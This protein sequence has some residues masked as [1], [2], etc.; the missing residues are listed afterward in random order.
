MWTVKPIWPKSTWTPWGER[1]DGP[2]PVAGLREHPRKP[3]VSCALPPWPP[4]GHL[5]RAEPLDRFNQKPNAGTE[6]R[7][8]RATEPLGGTPAVGRPTKASSPEPR[9]C[10]VL[11]HLRAWPFSRG[12]DPMPFPRGPPVNILVKLGR[13]ESLC[14]HRPQ[15]T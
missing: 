2:L 8:P 7:L 12:V 5:A 1:H 13:T 4:G 3:C 10:L 11:R 14:H 9:A 15:E 6:T